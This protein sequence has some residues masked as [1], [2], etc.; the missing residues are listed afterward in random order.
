MQY[1]VET[2][3]I[4]DELIL[5]NNDPRL[6]PAGYK[7]ALQPVCHIDPVFTET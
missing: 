7:I 4:I 5:T 2:Y 1:C 6:I 3:R